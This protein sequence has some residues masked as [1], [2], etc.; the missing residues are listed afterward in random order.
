MREAFH[1]YAKQNS[2]TVLKAS[3]LSPSPIKLD[4][5]R[6]GTEATAPADNKYKTIT[7]NL[8]GKTVCRK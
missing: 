8:Y 2:S 6:S 7:S 1:L 3:S 4:T 5:A